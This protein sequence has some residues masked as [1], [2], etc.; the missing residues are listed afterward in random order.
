MTQIAR[1]HT[2]GGGKPVIAG[3]RITVEYILDQLVHGRTVEHLLQEHSQLSREHIEAAVLYAID[4]VAGRAEAKPVEVPQEPKTPEERFHDEMILAWWWCKHG[5]RDRDPR[6][7][8]NDIR[9]Y[10][11]LSELGDVGPVQ[12]LDNTIWS[13][14]WPPVYAWW[15]VLAFLAANVI[16]TTPTLRVAL[17]LGPKIALELAL[18]YS[19]PLFALALLPVAPSLLWKVST[20]SSSMASGLSIAAHLV[21]SRGIAAE[22]RPARDSDVVSRLA[23]SSALERDCRILTRRARILST[24]IALAGIPGAI[25]VNLYSIGMF[26]VLVASVAACV[27]TLGR[28]RIVT[29]Q[30]N[31]TARAIVTAATMKRRE[32]TPLSAAD[33]ATSMK[34][35]QRRL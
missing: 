34:E 28:L 20:H 33:T 9:P 17:T 24:A 26:A 23:Q 5:S 12:T 25:L 10:L 32:E 1:D 7:L 30:V 31:A 27:D 22:P 13:S 2:T 35:L 8:T 18:E 4:A 16:A 15:G 3:T 19:L 11:V 29:S 14:I 6:C 21:A